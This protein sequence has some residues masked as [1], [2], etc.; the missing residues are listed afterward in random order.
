MAE[1]KKRKLLFITDSRSAFDANSEKLTSLFE[2]ADV[3]LSNPKAM[4]YAYDQ[5]YDVI[6]GDLTVSLETLTLLKQIKDMKKETL[7]FALVSPKDADKLYRIADLG[8]HAF[9]LLPEQ[10]DLALEAI[11]KFNT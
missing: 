9:E 7:F 4:K 3:A 10:F 1:P 11:A 2:K 5:A 6:V 8:I